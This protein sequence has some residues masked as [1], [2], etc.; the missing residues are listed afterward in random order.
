MTSER[1][2]AW[3]RRLREVGAALAREESLEP[4]FHLI[5]HSAI[6]LTEAERGFLVRVEK[7]PGGIKKRVEMALGFDGDALNSPAGKISKTVVQRVLDLDRDVVTTHEEDEDLIEISSVQARRVLS[8]ACV[9][10]RLRGE[11]VGVLYVDH[12]FDKAAF[13][14]AD[15]PCLRAFADQ[16]AL[17]LETARLKVVSAAEA[18]PSPSPA[19]RLVPTLDSIVRRGELVGDSPAMH[20]IQEEVD[21]AARSLTPLLI[22]GEVGSGKSA[23]AREVHARSIR[24]GE[25]VSLPCSGIDERDLRGKLFGHLDLVGLAKDGALVQAS[26]GTLVL[27]DLDSIPL[28]LQREIMTVL[29][30]RAFCAVGSDRP[31]PLLTRVVVSMSSD[32]DQLVAEGRLAE[33]L[34]CLLSLQ[35]ISVPSLRERV[36]D[37]PQ[38][39]VFLLGRE[40][41]GHGPVAPEVFDSL[42]QYSWP[43]NLHELNNLCVRLATFGGEL[44]PEALPREIREAGAPDQPS[45]TLE[46]VKRDL[47]VAALLETKGSRVAA[48]RKLNVPRSTFYRMLDRYGLSGK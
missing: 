14:E 31:Q 40:A 47:V 20:K 26:S 35:S 37:V 33:D 38:L 32:P 23:V 12:R 27:E 3:L 36:D 18:E 25:F 7:K 30:E 4:L 22:L 5:V 29:K 48:A 16:A 6:Q 17:A 8:I 11:T 15:L 21:R 9:P 19:P 39:F 44:T 13:T 34:R 45:R 43:G 1:E 2:L 41:P 42:V 10:M 46:E 28:S 24:K